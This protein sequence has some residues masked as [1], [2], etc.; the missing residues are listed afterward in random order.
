MVLKFK[1]S[2]KTSEKKNYGQWN[3]NKTRSSKKQQ[4]LVE[5]SLIMHSCPRLSFK[6]I[7]QLTLEMTKFVKLLIVVQSIPNN[8][9]PQ[10]KS[11]KV[12]VIGSLKQIAGS[13]G[14][15]SFNCTVNFLI[16]FNC[17]N[18]EWKLKDTSRL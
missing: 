16:T 2:G 5:R 7:C 14:K 9:N 15:T 6:V 18:V 10:G 11:K 13:K 3:D 4:N 8:S 12:W 1:N 17:R